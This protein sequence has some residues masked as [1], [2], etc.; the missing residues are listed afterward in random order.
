MQFRILFFPPPYLHFFHSS[1]HLQKHIKL[2]EITFRCD[3]MLEFVGFTDVIYFCFNLLNSLKS[4]GSVSAN[5]Q[6]SRYTYTKKSQIKID[7]LLVNQC[8]LFE[9]LCQYWTL[10]CKVENTHISGGKPCL[11]KPYALTFTS[12]YHLSFLVRLFTKLLCIERFSQFRLCLLKIVFETVN[13]LQFCLYPQVFIGNLYIFVNFQ[14]IQRF[15]LIFSNVSKLAELI[16]H[17]Q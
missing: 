17:L 9:V 3:V 4:K 8:S 15:N 1:C 16:I 14:I 7:R 10:K 13:A 11:N 2:L 6:Y 12:H 5:K